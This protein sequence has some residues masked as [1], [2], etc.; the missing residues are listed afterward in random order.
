MFEWLEQEPSLLAGLDPSMDAEKMEGCSLLWEY[1]PDEHR[2]H[3]RTREGTC[4]FP[5][6]TIPG[7]T[8]I[9]LS[10]AFIGSNHLWTRDRAVDLDGNKIYGFTSDEHHKFLHCRTYKGTIRF[11]PEQELEVI[12]HN[13]GQ[14]FRIGDTEY[15]LKL[16]QSTELETKATPTAL[17][18]GVSIHWTGLLDWTSGL[19]YWTH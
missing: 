11:G 9:G 18:L 12:I 10:D 14:K 16:A 8:I 15:F 5:S 1:L 17:K 19:D 4:R 2:F 3:G 13:Q 6:T 7:K